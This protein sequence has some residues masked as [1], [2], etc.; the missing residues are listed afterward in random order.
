MGDRTIE[1]NGSMVFED[2]TNN[3]KAVI[4]FSTYK[5]SGFFKKTV[6]GKKDEFIGIIYQCTPI[7]DPFET[8]KQL[9]SKQAADI[10]DLGKLKD[11]QKQLC[12]IQGSWMRNLIIDGKK[13]WDI[14]TDVP[15]RFR[16]HIEGVVPSDWRY[17]EDLI[18]LKYSY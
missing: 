14:D 5:K 12:E 10:K 18:W 6:S 15:D 13:Y 8:A 16:P 2:L 11:V 4:I 17:R 9:Y 1:A 7:K 3:F